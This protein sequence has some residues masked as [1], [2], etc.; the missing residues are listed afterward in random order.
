MKL[1]K[2]IYIAIHLVTILFNEHKKY[3][4]IKGAVG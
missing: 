1:S 4:N 2:N 3:T